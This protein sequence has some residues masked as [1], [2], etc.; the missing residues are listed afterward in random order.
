VRLPAVRLFDALLPP[1]SRGADPET[2]RQARV[3]VA[4]ASIMLVADIVYTAI[5]LALDLPVVT[6]IAG[7]EAI[8]T[9]GL[10]LAH[11]R[12]LPRV[13]AAN[14][15]I[16]AI[17]ICL[18]ATLTFEG[19]PEDT[20]FPWFMLLP[21][22]AFLLLGPRGGLPWFVAAC[23]LLEGLHATRDSVW[24][25]GLGRLGGG[26][27]SEALASHLG[28]TAV[29]TGVVWALGAS[30]ELAVRQHDAMVAR[31]QHAHQELTRA[32]GMAR[33]LLDHVDHAIVLVDRGGRTAPQC[34]RAAQELLGAVTPGMKVWRLFEDGNPRF[35][36][37][38]EA[39]WI[40]AEDGWMPLELALAQV[41]TQVELGG[42][43]LAITLRIVDAESATTPVLLVATDITEVV[44]AREAEQVSRQVATLLS[45]SVEEPYLVASFVAEGSRLVVGIC[46]GLWPAADQRRAVHTLKGSALVMGLKCLGGWLHA[47][48]DRMATADAGCSEEDRSRLAEAWQALVGPMQPLLE[49]DA[50]QGLRIQ[51]TELEDLVALVEGGAD[52]AELVAALRMLAW[53][54]VRPWL[55]QLAQRARALHLEGGRELA[56]V[57]DCDALRVPPSADWAGLW[58]TLVH[59]VRNAVDHGL[60]APELRAAVRKPAIG[61]LFLRASRSPSWLSLEIADDGPG[62]CWEAVA[63]KAAARGLPIEHQADLVE[64]LFTE[65]LSTRDTVTQTSGRGVGLSAVRFAARRLGGEVELSSVAGR[66][67]SV[68]IVL[69]LASSRSPLPVHRDTDLS[70]EGALACP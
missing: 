32:H 59:L 58:P 27:S 4:L 39:S 61:T 47:L 16:V 18:V 22:F 26:N 23:L 49:R 1:A 2:L 41:P 64:A 25:A 38:L 45:R 37:W 44:R 57:V 19:V 68:R 34:S 21:I 11:R 29:M 42:R 12:G 33:M 13:V 52:G 66:G 51:A 36:A 7:G 14:L 31:E 10:L 50:L 6:L 65:G 60:E 43:M 63:R 17:A 69:P 67:T 3:M 8:L 24:A 28:L 5:F 15:L 62:V 20:V 35:A 54:P 55:E 53:E 70:L 9:A 40:S 30:R 56:V 46:G 48:E